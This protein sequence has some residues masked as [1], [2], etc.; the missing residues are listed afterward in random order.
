MIVK[1]HA[2]DPPSTFD[3]C[4]DWL[5]SIVPEPAVWLYAIRIWAAMMLALYSAF[6]LQLTSASSAAVCVAILAQPKRGQ[7]LSKAGYRFLGTIVGAVVALVLTGLF[8]QD[9]VLLL[10]SFTTWL[11]LCTFTANYLQDTRSYGAMLSGYTVAIIAIA[12]IDDPQDVFAATVGRVAAITVGIL[13]ITFINDALA[14]PNTWRSLRDTLTQTLSATK[15]YAREVLTAGDPGEERAAALVER[16]AVM[17]PDA[18]AIAGEFDDGRRRAA[19]AKSAIAALYEMIVACRAFAAA[20]GRIAGASE[21][22]DEARGICLASLH[23]ASEDAGSGTPGQSRDRLRTLIDAAMGGGSPHLDEIVALQG[24]LDL[25]DAVAYA[26]DGLAAVCDGRRPLRDVTLSIYRDFPVAFAAAMRVAIAFALSALFFIVTGW[27]AASFALVQAAAN[28]TLSSTAPDQKKFA[29][30]ML[31]GQ[32][33]AC[34][35]AGIAL[36]VFLVGNQGFPI[37]AITFAPVVLLCCALISN[38]S[39]AGIGTIALVFFPIM[40]APNNPQGYDIQTFLTNS[41]LVVLGVVIV[42][43]AVRIVLP[44]SPARHRA[45]AFASAR[46]DLVAAL[47]GRRDDATADTSRNADRLLQFLRW[48]SGVAKVRAA[49]LGHAFTLVQLHAAVTR[50]QAQLRS[51][52]RVPALQGVVER[53][54]AELA[55]VDAGGLAEAAR[56]LARLA[57]G[58]GPANRSA[59]ARTVS[60]LAVSSRLIESRRHF[61]R[62]LR[63]R[64][65]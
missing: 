62:H 21:P 55:A 24:A 35:L 52:R 17:R 18:N 43:L 61:L 28:C 42:F 57:A 32:P 10:V 48:N 47:N 1:R 60:D 29:L 8:G 63:L 14:S 20:A 3:R 49:R 27:P 36:F 59:A 4:L 46:A 7:A 16:I 45:I 15:A 13:A 54:R 23:G 56:D 58:E 38:P 2:F 65:D 39:T 40:V 51:L 64:E 44:I 19:G 50:A 26:H 11:G 12:H 53:A 30:G 33:L 41:L 5:D 37:L 9:R 34:L 31:I 22:L 6:W 25:V